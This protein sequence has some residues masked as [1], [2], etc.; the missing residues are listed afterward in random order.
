MTGFYIAGSCGLFVVGSVALTVSAFIEIPVRTI[1]LPGYL[2][3]IVQ[4]IFVLIA[5]L[6]SYKVLNFYKTDSARFLQQFLSQYLK[7]K[8]K[9]NVSGASPGHLDHF[10]I[11]IETELNGN[12]YDNAG[13]LPEMLHTIWNT[14]FKS[15]L[16]YA[17]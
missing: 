4:I 9:E 1:T 7:D 3:N 16:T 14:K 12:E 17:L 2:Q 13:T 10:T 11:D 8:D 5:V 15:F 6:V